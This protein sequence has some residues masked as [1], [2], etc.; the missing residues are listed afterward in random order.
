MALWFLTALG[1]APFRWL[2][3][4]DSVP[5][6]SAMSVGLFVV[7]QILGQGRTV[8]WLNCWST[9]AWIKLF[10]AAAAS[11]TVFLALNCTAIVLGPLLM[12]NPAKDFVFSGWLPIWLLFEAVS[13]VS[14]YGPWWLVLRMGWVDAATS[15]VPAGAHGVGLYVAFLLRS[16]WGLDIPIMFFAGW[17]L[18]FLPGAVAAREC[19]P[20][21]RKVGPAAIRRVVWI[22]PAVTAF[23]ALWLTGRLLDPGPQR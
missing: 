19:T 12:G 5:L 14:W 11:T 13:L 2:S 22:V 8:G 17:S 16:A 9:P 3:A 7:L 21:T 6:L 4:G 15:L 23:M 18:M 1:M 20:G 10:S